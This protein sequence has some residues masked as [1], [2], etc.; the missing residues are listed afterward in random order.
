MPEATQ[1]QGSD[2][3]AAIEPSQPQN[4]RASVF[5]WIVVW[6]EVGRRIGVG[7]EL[8]AGPRAG[9]AEGD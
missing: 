5:D 1:F 9:K 3:P 6:L 4:A 2:S 8:G 7:V